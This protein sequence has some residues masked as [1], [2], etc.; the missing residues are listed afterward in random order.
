MGSFGF[1]FILF[2]IFVYLKVIYEALAE[3]IEVEKS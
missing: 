2:F 1:F 3:F